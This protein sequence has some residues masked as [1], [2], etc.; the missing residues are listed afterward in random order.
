M[1]LSKLGFLRYWF[2]IDAL[3]III[4]DVDFMKNVQNYYDQE[5]ITGFI[6][7]KLDNLSRVKLY[8]S[9]IYLKW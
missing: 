2:C 1:D 9:I 6:F 3:N 8:I 4:A 7:Q 5:L